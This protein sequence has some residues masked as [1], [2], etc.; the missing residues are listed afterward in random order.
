MTRRPSLAAFALALMLGWLAVAITV[1]TLSVALGQ[2]A[3][4]VVAPAPAPD[5]LARVEVIIA[6][7]VAALMAVERI[8]AAIRAARTRAALASV[9]RAIEDEGAGS[10]V[11]ARIKRRASVEANKRG[12]TKTLSR[13]VLDETSKPRPEAP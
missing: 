2:D 8:L 7:V 1:G 3:A 4:P 10:D 11:G 12:A 13:A 9:A 6:G 5:P